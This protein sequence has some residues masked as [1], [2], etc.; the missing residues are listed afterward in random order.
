MLYVIPL[1]IEY[2]LEEKAK[3]QGHNIF[4]VPK[5]I[6]GIDQEHVDRA[7]PNTETFAMVPR[8]GVLSIEPYSPTIIESKQPKLGWEQVAAE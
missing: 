3:I 7:D 6:V 5:C 4:V 2:S 8:V 1:K